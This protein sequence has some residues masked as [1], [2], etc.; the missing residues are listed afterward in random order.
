M[1]SE[2]ARGRRRA[3]DDAERGAAGGH[4]RF[5]RAAVVRGGRGWRRGRAKGEVVFAAGQPREHQVGDVRAG[6]EQNEGDG[7][8]Q[9]RNRRPH[10]AGQHPREWNGGH[11]F[12][13]VVSRKLPE[14]LPLH[15]RGPEWRPPAARRPGTGDR[16]QVLAAAAGGRLRAVVSDQR[17]HVRAPI[18]PLGYE[19]LEPRRHHANDGELEIVH[20]DDPPDRGRVAVEAAAPCPS[21]RR[22]TRQP[23]GVSSSARKSRPIAGRTPR[24][25]KNSPRRACRRSAPGCRRPAESDSGADERHL[26]ERVAAVAPVEERRVSDVARRAVGSDRQSSPGARVMHAAAAAAGRR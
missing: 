4:Q 6:D 12:G 17:P 19:R 22:T 16:L 3:D 5:R 18:E 25:W 1:P 15:G 9:N 14:Q 11:R 23:F 24:V 13:R 7:A 8:H 21:L 20:R 2:P 10:V 26:F